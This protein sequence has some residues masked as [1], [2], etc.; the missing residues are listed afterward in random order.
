VIILLPELTKVTINRQTYIHAW[1]RERVRTCPGNI[2]VRQK[3]VKVGTKVLHM[4]SPVF[5]YNPSFEPLH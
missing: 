1:C 5:F 4:V 2:I 3:R